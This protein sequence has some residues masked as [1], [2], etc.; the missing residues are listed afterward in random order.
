[1]NLPKVPSVYSPFVERE[2]NRTLEQ[3]SKFV[4]RTDN[5]VDIGNERLILTSPDG[6][7]FSVTVANDGTLSATSI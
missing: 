6:T 7:R 5:D 3:E 1:M 2:R 4:R